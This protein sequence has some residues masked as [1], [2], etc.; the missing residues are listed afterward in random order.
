VSVDR[1]EDVPSRALAVFAHPDDADVACAG[2]LARWVDAGSEVDLVICALGDKGSVDPTVK[3][4]TLARRRQ[5]EVEEAA[6]IV[7]INRVHQL[8]RKDGEFENDLGIRRELVTLLRQNRPQVVVCPDPLAVFFGEHYYNHR[9]HRVVGYATLD[10]AAPAASSPLYFPDAGPPHAVDFVL[11]SG[12]LDPNASVDVTATIARKVDAVT[13]HRSQLGESAESMR[14]VIEE[15]AAEAGRTVGV[16]F[17][18]SFRR[19]WLVH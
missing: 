3:G 2:T 10:A 11:L 16:E 1:L 9:D 6:A 8:G 12:T 18:E 19:V 4:P 13:C 15:R 5:R 14:S 7:G 17:A